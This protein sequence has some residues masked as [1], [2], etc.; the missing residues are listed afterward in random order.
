[1]GT[2]GGTSRA[3][4][5]VSNCIPPRGRTKVGEVGGQTQ[6]VG[7]KWGLGEGEEKRQGG[8]SRAHV[9]MSAAPPPHLMVRVG[10]M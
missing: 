6:E 4:V 9:L 7:G 2:R 1:M 10:E 3:A 8:T 5:L